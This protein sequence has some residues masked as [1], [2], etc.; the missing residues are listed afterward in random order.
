MDQLSSELADLFDLGKIHVDQGTFWRGNY[1]EEVSFYVDDGSPQPGSIEKLDDNL[2]LD[3]LAAPGHLLL[4]P[5]NSPGLPF[6]FGLRQEQFPAS[7][8]VGQQQCQ[9][10]GK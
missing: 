7:A 1:F 6:L 4:Q 5:G 2:R 3:P 10:P 9:D 8:S